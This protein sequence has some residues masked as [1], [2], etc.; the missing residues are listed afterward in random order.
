MGKE[1]KIYR[2][3]LNKFSFYHLDSFSLIWLTVALIWGIRKW[4]R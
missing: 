2:E 1:G 3:Y 4:C